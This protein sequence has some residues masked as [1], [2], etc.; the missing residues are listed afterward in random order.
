MA[1][2]TFDLTLHSALYDHGAMQMAILH[3]SGGSKVL[4]KSF[5]F[6]SCLFIVIITGM[7]G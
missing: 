2:Q 3:C 1:S 5:Q 7:Q 6:F 4:L